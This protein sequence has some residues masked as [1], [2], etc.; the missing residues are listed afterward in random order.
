M[1]Y[2]NAR[3]DNTHEPPTDDVYDCFD[4]LQQSI[5]CLAD[6]NLEDRVVS[7]LG[8]VV[9][10]GYGNHQCRDSAG[11]FAFAEKWR[12][13]NGKTFQERTNLSEGEKV[14]GGTVGHR[15]VTSQGGPASI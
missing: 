4:Y 5:T 3:N 14:P 1:A 7:E 2:F 13:W 15:M 10:S 11:V 8:H 12:V 6:T 9:F